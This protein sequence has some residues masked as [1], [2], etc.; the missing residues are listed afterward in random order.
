M[1]S[2]AAFAD[3]AAGSRPGWLSAIHGPWLLLIPALI[4][5]VPAYLIP[6]GQLLLTSFGTG[7]WTLAFYE[8]ALTDEAFMR[9]LYR[10]VILSA[11]VTLITDPRDHAPYDLIL[12]DAPCSGSGSWR[13]DPQGKWALT[14]ARLA[15]LVKIQAQIL[16]H[17]TTLLAPDG[18]LAYATCSLLG[19]ENQAQ[20]KS[21]LRRTPG[22]DAVQTRWSPLSGCD[23][24]FLAQMSRN[25]ANL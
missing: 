24:F 13:R 7:K 21:F 12:I 3:G 8:E 1:Q 10:T 5:L 9:V 4:V 2:S 22:F 14:A 11:Q 19:C 16:D 25:V 18:V 15:E 6:V 23:G 20:I 17:A